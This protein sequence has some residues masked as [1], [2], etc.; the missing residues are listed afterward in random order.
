MSILYSVCTFIILFFFDITYLV[1]FYV[2]F[3]LISI[4]VLFRTWNDKYVQYI[5]DI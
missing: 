5:F 3:Y 2:F 4:L 1:Q